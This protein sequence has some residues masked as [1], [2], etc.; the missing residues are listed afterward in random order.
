MKTQWSRSTNR[1]QQ[2]YNTIFLSPRTNHIINSPTNIF[3]TLPTPLTSMTSKTNYLNSLYRDI[4]NYYK[5]MC[6]FKCYV[7]FWLRAVILNKLQ[8]RQQ[9]IYHTLTTLSTR[10]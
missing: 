1:H 5:Q 9:L 2:V 8:Q 3:P 4:S 10:S 6:R 7:R